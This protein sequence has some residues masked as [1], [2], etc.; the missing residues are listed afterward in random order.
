M[1]EELRQARE[2][3]AKTVQAAEEVYTPVTEQS[4]QGAGALPRTRGQES[5]ARKQQK[6]TTLRDVHRKVKWRHD[7]RQWSSAQEPELSPIAQSS[8]SLTPHPGKS[9]K[10]YHT[11]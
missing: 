3:V 2:A 1:S 9:P 7:S 8:R 11:W 6:Q 5:D 4:S 10:C